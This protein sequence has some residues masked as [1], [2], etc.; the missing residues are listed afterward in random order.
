MKLQFNYQQ[1]IIEIFIEFNYLC[2]DELLNNFKLIKFLIILENNWNTFVCEI[3]SIN[4]KLLI[5]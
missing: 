1:S 2:N 4:F 5:K 3:C